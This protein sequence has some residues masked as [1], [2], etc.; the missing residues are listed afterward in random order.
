MNQPGAADPL[1]KNESGVLSMP[2]PRLEK[3]SN[4]P[5]CTDTVRVLHGV[6]TKKKLYGQV[7]RVR[8]EYVPE[9]VPKPF[10]DALYLYNRD[11]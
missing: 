5:C 1:E 2:K 4:W 10:W 3:S 7:R 6:C 9:Y 11:A 8:T